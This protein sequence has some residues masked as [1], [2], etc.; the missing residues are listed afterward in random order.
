VIV[1]L[2]VG[3][4]VVINIAPLIAVLFVA[5]MILLVSGLVM[6][7]REV[8]VATRHMRQGME[9]ALEGETPETTAR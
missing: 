1:T 3:E 6:L 8:S 7:L 5:A 9:L 2:F 4:Y